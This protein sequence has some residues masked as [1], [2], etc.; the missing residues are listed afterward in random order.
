MHTAGKVSS[1]DAEDKA[2]SEYKKYRKDQDE[3]C[4]SDFDREIKKILKSKKK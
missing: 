1:K 4:I 3:K 2:L